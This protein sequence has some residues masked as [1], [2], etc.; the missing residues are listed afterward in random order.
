MED[1]IYANIYLGWGLPIWVLPGICHFRWQN[2]RRL[3]AQHPW[4]AFGN[5]CW[6]GLLLGYV[7]LRGRQLAMTA[8]HQLHIIV[9][10]LGT[11]IPSVCF[12][13]AAA[14]FRRSGHHRNA[15]AHFD[16]WIG[17]ADAVR[18]I[19]N[20]QTDRHHARHCVNIFT[21]GPENSLPESFDLGIAR[22]FSSLCYAIEN[23]Y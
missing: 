9:A 19:F 3:M 5:L 4:H 21:C 18:N 10:L 20:H 14:Y 2:W 11:A 1:N 23:I 15:G 16:L 8:G 22:M 7:Y 13:Y 12:Y 17:P 6:P